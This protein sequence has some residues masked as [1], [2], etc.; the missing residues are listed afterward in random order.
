MG[1]ISRESL[2]RQIQGRQLDPVYVLFGSETFLRDEA[3]RRIADACFAEGDLRE[4]NESEFSLTVEGDLQRALAAAD[5][6][7]MMAGR[8][9]I[10]IIDVRV[11]AGGKLDTLNE[12]QER[13]LTHYFERPSPF[14]VVV[15]IADELNGV[16]K[17]G[18]LLRQNAT[19]FESAELD[20]EAATKW[21]RNRFSHARAEIDDATLRSFLLR[22]GTNA[23]RIANEAEKVATA[24]LPGKNIT[25]ELVDRLVPHSRELSNFEITNALVSSDKRRALPLLRKALADG[26]EPLMILGLISYNFRRL[27][28]AKDMMSRGADRGEIVRAINLRGRDQE[29]FLAT[30][31]RAERSQLSLAI[32]R[33]AETDV[34]IKTSLGGGGPFGG[35]LQIE[36]LVAEL[37][38]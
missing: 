37:A 18:K 14:S 32:S 3:A 5:Q 21:A 29:T 31:R 8:R 34:S 10:R 27:L 15:F 17:M 12:D 38:G 25:A 2:W 36:M 20:D 11:T 33:I 16:R 1:L 9:V 28:I 6:L 26:A 7:P 23:A 24:V 13:I 19:A 30:A 22:T 4:F 35:R